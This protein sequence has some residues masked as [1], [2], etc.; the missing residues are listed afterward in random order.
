MD[1]LFICNLICIFVLW[2]S[3]FLLLLIFFKKC[4]LETI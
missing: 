1:Y 4:W 3:I 2:E